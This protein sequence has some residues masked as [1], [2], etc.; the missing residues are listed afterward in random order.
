MPADAP[1]GAWKRAVAAGAKVYLIDGP[2]AQ[3]LK[4]MREAIARFGWYNAST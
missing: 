4:F 2:F 1:Q 3:S